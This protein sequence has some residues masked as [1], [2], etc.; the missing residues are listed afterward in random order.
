[1]PLRS[2]DFSLDIDALLA[3]IERHQPALLFLAYPNNP[4]GNLFDAA[5]IE[6]VIEVAPGIVVVDEAYAP[7]TDESFMPRLGEFD[8]PAGD[9][10]CLQDGIGRAASRFAGW[11]RRLAGADRQDP[12]AL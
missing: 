4:T 8:T 3:A 12:P 5:E 6:R 2:D 1:M 10:Y 9:A 11:A 7:F